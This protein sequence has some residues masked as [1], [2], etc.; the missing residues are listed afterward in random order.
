MYLQRIT[1]DI[2][3]LVA[4]HSFGFAAVK[5]R[6]CKVTQ[7]RC[8]AIKGTG[9]LNPIRWQQIRGISN[10]KPGRKAWAFANAWTIAA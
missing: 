7:K 6:I 2:W 1:G 10:R 9:V 3:Q 8:L 5:H 4:E